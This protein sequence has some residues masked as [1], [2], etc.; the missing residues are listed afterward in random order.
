[1]ADTVGPVVIEPGSH[2]DAIREAIQGFA[3]STAGEH[4]LVNIAIVVW[5]ET[6][7]D[8]DGDVQ[9]R[10]RYVIPTDSFSPVGVLG[11]LAAGRHIVSRDVLP[12]G[13]ED[14]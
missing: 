7:M 14:G 10:T 9:A 11:L 4:V 6:S 13:D 2:L 8:D 1:M 3:S 12:H 5:E